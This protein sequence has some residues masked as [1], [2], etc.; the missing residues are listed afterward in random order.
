MYSKGEGWQSIQG[1]QMSGAV[2]LVAGKRE[3]VRVLM[4]YFKKFPFTNEFFKTEIGL[5]NVKRFRQRFKVE[6]YAY[7]PDKI[8]YIDNRIRFGF[9]GEIQLPDSV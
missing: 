1:L 7:I 4:E 6:L 2:T 8:F 3:T 9:R 5:P